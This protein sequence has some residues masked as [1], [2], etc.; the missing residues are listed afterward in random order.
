V[1]VGADFSAASRRAESAGGVVERGRIGR[2]FVEQDKGSAVPYHGSCTFL[3]ELGAFSPSERAIGWPQYHM[4]SGGFGSL[5]GRL[6]LRRMGATRGPLGFL[7]AF[8]VILAVLVAVG[9]AF[10]LLISNTDSAAPSGIYLVVSREVKRDETVA[11]CLPLDIALQG[12]T[13]GYLR[14]GEC[15]GNAEPVGKIAGA[16]PGDVV[17][18]ER[19]WIAVS[20]RRI[21]HSAVASHDSAGRPL[22]RAS[23]G[24]HKVAGREVWLLGLN[25]RRRW[26]SRYFGPVPLASVRAQVEP[27]FHVVRGDG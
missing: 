8:A 13:R 19:D 9:E 3:S 17:D 21:P 24:K 27:I 18:I 1:K 15:L 14:T 7:A 4:V 11:A 25:D 16:L 23:W 5:R 22:H 10:G 12:L 20:A 6:A 26:E 2:E